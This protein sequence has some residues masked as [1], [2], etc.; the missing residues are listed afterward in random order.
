[1]IYD[2]CIQYDKSSL[3]W[4]RSFYLASRF[5]IDPSIYNSC[6]PRRRL[7]SVRFSYKAILGPAPSF[8]IFAA[9]FSAPSRTRSTFSPARPARSCWDQPPRLMSS[10]NC[11]WEASVSAA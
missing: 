11:K 3:Q 6:D 7:I 5:S 8:F 4:N 10:A 2:T 9:V 1:M